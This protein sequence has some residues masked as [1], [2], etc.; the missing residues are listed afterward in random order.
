M[1]RSREKPIL[2]NLL[3]TDIAAEGKAIAKY[4]GIIVF[5][6]QCVP[7]DVVDVQ[8]IRNRRRFME[9]YPV[10]FHTYSAN[11]SKPFCKHFG[12]CGGCKWQHLPYKKQLEFKQKQVADNLERIG[13]IE[14]SLK[15]GGFL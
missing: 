8:I 3:I 12:V 1:S 7:G 10:L 5:V 6:S 15:I 13:K 9:G 2:Q 14:Y 4:E 11:R